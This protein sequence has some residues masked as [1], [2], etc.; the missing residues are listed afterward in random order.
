L[1]VT[2]RISNEVLSLPM[3][4]GLTEKEIDYV[5]ETIQSYFN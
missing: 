3:Y 2:E 5:I 1:P 4:E